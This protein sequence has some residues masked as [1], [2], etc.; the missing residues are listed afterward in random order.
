MFPLS[1]SALD[2]TIFE[3]QALSLTLP[4]AEGELTI[5]ENHIPLITS[6]TK[7]RLLIKT[8]KKEF[9]FSIRGGILQV[10]PEK[11]IVLVNL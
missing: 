3:D 5:L 6:L 7:G 8:E 2:K 9:N 11:V 4:G 10:S 1:I